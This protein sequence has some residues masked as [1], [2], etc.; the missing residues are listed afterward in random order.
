MREIIYNY[1]HLTDKDITETVIRTKALIVNGDD[2]FLGN[3]SN[4]IQFPGGHLEERETLEECLK[5]EVL[6]ETG[7]VIE[8]KEIGK[9]FL[10]ITYLNKDWPK[11]GGN[12]KADIYYYS[13]KT[14]KEPDLTKVSYTEHEKKGKFKIE[15]IPLSNSIELIKNNIPN[16][17]KNKVIAPD[18]II[19][20]EE[21]LHQCKN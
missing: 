15:K 12:R 9:P 17:K 1:D 11:K 16:N 13:I 7:I 8:D 6:E 5:R 21:Y 2:I 19:A 4:I 20:I 14:K 18:M 3:E 10:N